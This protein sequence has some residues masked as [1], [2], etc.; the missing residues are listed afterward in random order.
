M[1]VKLVS[2][3]AG[4]VRPL[5]G[6][7]LQALTDP[8]LQRN[9]GA[10]EMFLRQCWTETKDPG[11]YADLK[12]GDRPNW[13]RV[14]LGDRFDALCQLRG[15]TFGADYGFRVQCTSRRCRESYE[16]ELNLADLPR[17]EL[18]KASFDQ[19]ATGKNEFIA[20]A[21]D[22]KAITFRLPTGADEKAASKLKRSQGGQWGHLDAIQQYLIEIDGVGSA[23]KDSKK[24]RAYLEDLSWPDLISLLETMSR[25][26]CGVDIKLET[27]CTFCKWVQDVLLPFDEDFFRPRKKKV[28]PKMKES[29]RISLDRTLAPPVS[30]KT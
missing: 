17:Q 30:S 10:V 13:D 15:M 21:P 12:V 25:D 19:I 7:E 3:L 27:E 26:D 20:E 11:P 8:G 22:G 2:G 28:D 9:G 29:E 18:P 6:S 14:L 23:A 16:W 1:L 4:E 5:K 24:V